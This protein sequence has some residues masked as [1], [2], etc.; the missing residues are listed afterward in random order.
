MICSTK[1]C[2]LIRVNSIG[3]CSTGRLILSHVGRIKALIA[4]EYKVI[5]PATKLTWRKAI[6][7]LVEWL[8]STPSSWTKTSSSVVTSSAVCE[9]TS[10]A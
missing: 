1:V 6:L 5:G 3:L 2:I 9:M 4:L 8:A 7:C 10:P